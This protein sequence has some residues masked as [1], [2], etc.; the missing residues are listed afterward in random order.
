MGQRCEFKDLD[1]SY[2]RKLHDFLGIQIAGM[3]GIQIMKGAVIQILTRPF[4]AKI[5]VVYHMY[6]RHLNVCYWDPAC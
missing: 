5:K 6:S 3:F 2:L 1:G 4:W